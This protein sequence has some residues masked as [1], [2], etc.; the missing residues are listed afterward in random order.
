MFNYFTL[1]NFDFKNKIVGVRIDI[2]SP[3]I[4]GKVILNERITQS[5]ITINELVKKG[6]KIILLAHQGRMGKSDF[7]SLKEHCKLLSKELNKNI[8]FIDDLYSEKVVKKIDSLNQEEIILLENLRFYDDEINFSKRENKLTKLQNHFDFYVF[9]AFSLSH[10]KQASV[11]NFN[12]IPNIAGRL[13][14]KE[15]KGLS[16][17]E[18]TN[19]PHIFLF[20]GAKPDDLITLIDKGLKSNSCDLVLLTGVI[21]EIALK[22]KGYDLG[23]KIKYL[24]EHDFL[25]IE[26]QLKKLLEKYGDKIIFPKDVAI[27]DGKS[28]IEID[29][30]D[31]DKNKKLINEYSIQDIGSKT[32]SY[33]KLFFK[34]AGSIYF[35]GPCGNFE[36]KEFEKGTKEIL[37]EVISSNSFTFMGGGHSI[38]AA[39]MFKV[40]DKFSYTSLAGG[41]LV[42]FLSN[43]KLFGVEN[44]ET[45]YVKFDKIYEDFVVVG[46]N[47]LDYFVTAPKYFREIQLGEKIRVDENFKASIGGGGINVSVCLSKLGGKVGYLGKLSYESYN[48]IKEDLDSH[49]IRLIESKKTRTPA[50]KSILLDTKDGDRV[51]FTFRGQNQYLSIDD[52]NSEDFRA[53]HYYFTS[54]QGES[55]NTQLKL[56]KLIRK[57]NLHAKICYNTSSS[58]VQKESKLKNL[59]NQCDI[60]ILNYEEA[61]AFLK[62][63]TPSV[64]A[65]LQKLKKLVNEL[66]IITDGS[67]GSYCYDGDR[68]YFTKAIKPK[69]IIDTT[70]AGDSFGGTFFYFYSKG[71][72]VEKSLEFAATNSSSVVSK[73]GAQP[74]LLDYKEILKKTKSFQIK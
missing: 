10:R 63:D 70:G 72:G 54:L 52:F 11:I 18:K 58:L 44:L 48:Q 66:V 46:S 16:R 69:K 14:E 30:E 62:N 67:N 12:N 7:V 65:C 38:T 39:S 64:S 5:C 29:I 22:I 49:N 28:R 60:L 74:G 27:F 50:S 6:A 57:R 34:M 68:E 35:K 19:K 53:N 31:L 25:V 26:D 21:G 37:K 45:S 2:N 8:D 71:Y 24:K 23:K 40:L 20:G 73:K 51:I 32:I 47:V 3:V 59:I 1:E 55:F 36:F 41:A 9:D 4:N 13:M 33:Y 61:Q 56:A 42:K 43:E 17:I 15:L